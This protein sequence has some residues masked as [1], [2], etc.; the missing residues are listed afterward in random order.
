MPA[1]RTHAHHPDT[2]RRHDTVHRPSPHFFQQYDFVYL[3]EGTP[4]LR[5]RQALRSADLFRGA[6]IAADKLAGCNV[7]LNMALRPLQDFHDRRQLTDST[8]V[9]GPFWTADTV[10]ADV[11][12]RRQRIQIMGSQ[13]IRDSSL[14]EYPRRVVFTP[15]ASELGAVAAR[16]VAHR[17]GTWHVTIFQDRTDS[18]REAFFRQ[19]IQGFRQAA[20]ERGIPFEVRLLSP[21]EVSWR[22]IPLELSSHMPDSQVVVVLSVNS[23]FVSG[24]LSYLVEKTTDLELAKVGKDTVIPVVAFGL[25][26]WQYFPHADA[27]IWNRLG[28]EVPTP[29]YIDY[30]RPD[31]QRF[32]RTFRQRYSA[33]PSLYAFIGFDIT[34]AAGLSIRKGGYDFLHHLAMLPAQLLVSGARFQPVRAEGS[35]VNRH[36]WLLKFVHYRWQ[37]IDLPL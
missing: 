5:N 15:L 3:L 17:Y 7:R 13:P 27:E 37:R 36:V 20:T 21:R 28:I 24:L 25:P 9:I 31:V 34:Y 19:W 32:V 30:H 33:E 2:T 26:Q 6:L 10:V 4:T 16:R 1:P 8:I 11:C 35:W 22:K 14:L 18:V 23:E 12:R 29:Y